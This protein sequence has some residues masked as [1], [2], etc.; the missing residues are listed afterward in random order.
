MRLP[1]RYP[2]NRLNPGTLTAPGRFCLV[3]LRSRP[4]TVHR[5]PSRKTQIS[6]SLLR[7][8]FANKHPLR[9]I[10]PAIA[11]CRY[12]APLAPRL[13]R[14]VIISL[15]CV[16]VNNSIEQNASHRGSSNEAFTSLRKCSKIF[17]CDNGNTVESPLL[18][19]KSCK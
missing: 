2:E 5:F 12:K 14:N 13:A 16:N 11:D 9:N 8:C 7:G 10:T 19:L 17:V 3:L 4:D 15:F 18:P 1:K 6:T